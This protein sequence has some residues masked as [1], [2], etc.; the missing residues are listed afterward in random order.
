MPDFYPPRL[1]PVFARL[2]QS[3]APLVAD[4]KYRLRLQVDT[5]DLD[6][7]AALHD[8][9]LLLLPNHPSHHD[10]LAVF[11]LSA[12][13]GELFHYLAAYEQF[14]RP[15]GWLLQAIGAYSV[16]R[17]MGDRA[18]IAFT[19]D[20]LTQERCRLVVFPEGGY[21]FQNDTVMPFRPGPVQLAFQAINRLVKQGAPPPDFY[22]VP[23]SLKYRYR[24]NM[25][26]AIHN[27]L[28][29]LERALGIQGQGDCYQR[30]LAVADCVL[31][32]FEQSY[33]VPVQA[34][35]ESAG[36][37][38]ERSPSPDRNERIQTIKRHVLQTCEQQL[39]LTP[40]PQDPLRERVYRIQNAVNARADAQTEVVETSELWSNDAIQTAA[41]R[42]LNFD[43][44][45]DGYVAANPTPER[46]L[47]TL[48][49][50]ERSVF[51]IDQPPPK[52]DRSVI[53]RV[54]A[55]LNLK[56]FFTAY[57]QNR[58]KTLEQV[59]ETL[60]DRVQANV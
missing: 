16:K 49:R 8:H 21:S 37:T 59:T 12:R 41:A 23:L 25:Q 47:D 24:G 1:N 10:W 51:S 6:R 4:V 42:L 2:C 46:F 32:Q 56:D 34:V 55:P 54:G 18:S 22:A 53:I 19:L 3:L 33:G 5:A 35:V 44:I 28:L 38:S 20:L 30:L 57:T 17:G 14:T 40:A 11:L 60:R 36:Q 13:L 7:L 48:T 29:R 26:P 45:Y 58:Q 52:G 27:T 39:G 9:R 15:T 31:D 50:L 43:A